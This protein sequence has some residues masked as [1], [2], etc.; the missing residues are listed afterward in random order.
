MVAIL[1]RSDIARGQPSRT[2][3]GEFIDILATRGGLFA[4]QFVDPDQEAG[5]ADRARVLSRDALEA[6]EGWCFVEVRAPRAEA[7][8]LPPPSMDAL[9]A[10]KMIQV[11]AASTK[12]ISAG[13][14][15]GGKTFSASAEAQTKWMG[16]YVGRDLMPYP[17]SVPTINDEDTVEIAGPAD[18]VTFWTALLRHVHGILVGG[19]GLKVEV[20]RAQTELGL[21]RVVDNR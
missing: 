7:P 15:V 6:E 10:A 16:M 5:W 3:T 18:V 8:T 19:V 20:Q 2:S 14:E 17:F 4:V 9:K 11:D 13:F 1:S 21:A 12:L